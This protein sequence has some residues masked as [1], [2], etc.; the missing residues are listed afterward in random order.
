MSTLLT[1][2]II[3]NNRFL[4]IAN[5]YISTVEVA[6]AMN[7][8]I[9]YLQNLRTIVDKNL[10]TNLLLW[11]DSTGGFNKRV[12]GADT[13]IPKAYENFSSAQFV[14][15]TQ[16]IQP[17]LLSLG[18]DFSTG[19]LRH[20]FASDSPLNI[21]AASGS[22]ILSFGFWFKRTSIGTESIVFGEEYSLTWRGFG[23]K[24]NSSNRLV[25]TTFGVKGYIFTPTFTSTTVWNHVC[26]V[27]DNSFDVKLYV[28]GSYHSTITHTVVGIAST[29]LS[30]IISSNSL[31]DGNTNYSRTYLND[32]RL[33]NSNLTA[34]QISDW[35]NSTSSK[36]A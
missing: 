8:K 32:I 21:F 15:S 6:D 35:Y 3:Q 30:Y 36:Y 11:I 19:G 31:W 27:Y 34:T 33:Y 9:T 4:G 2:G 25:F 23:V 16:A 10:R 17:K 12:V 1:G 7:D 28:N 22:K 18:I 24:F 5:P 14:N 13:F 20:A 29:M 26:F